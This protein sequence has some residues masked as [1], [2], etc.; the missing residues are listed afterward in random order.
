MSH[1]DTRRRFLRLAGVTVTAGIAG[2]GGNGGDGEESPEQ[3]PGGE[4]TDTLEPVPAEY[5]TATSQ[6][7]SQRDPAALSTKEALEY[8]TEPSE[9]EQCSGCTF[10]I[11]DK[12]GNGM[13]ACTLVEGEIDP[14]GWCVSYAPLA[15]GTGTD[16]G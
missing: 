1:D 4:A 15:T 6:G 11:P 3:S 9:G 12:D 2:C 16:S 14:Q 5:E 8:Q 10:Y 13:G 7:G